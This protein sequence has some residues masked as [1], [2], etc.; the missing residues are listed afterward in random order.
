MTILDAHSH[1]TKPKQSVPSV[2]VR[3]TVPY[4]LTSLTS[5][6]AKIEPYPLRDLG[7]DQEA[8]F[9]L[10]SGNAEEAATKTYET[11]R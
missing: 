3:S 6:L 9:H 4:D 10:V 2:Q 8:P 1:I 7:I 11:R 5:I